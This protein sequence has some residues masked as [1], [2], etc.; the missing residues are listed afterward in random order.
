MGGRFLLLCWAGA[1]LCFWEGGSS[2]PQKA[3]PPTNLCLYF[4]VP[5]P[6]VDEQAEERWGPK[7]HGRP[8]ASEIAIL[9]A[10]QAHFDPA[11][12]S[13]AEAKNL[14]KDRWAGDWSEILTSTPAEA[15]ASGK[16]RPHEWN[17]R[18][19]WPD[20]HVLPGGGAST[21]CNDLGVSASRV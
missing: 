7:P 11:D 14:P 19:F 6:K 3:A 17:I 12:P 16:P 21:V 5:Y 20:I 4:C 1:A 2:P 15:F 18:Q 13:S 10:K 8:S 9:S